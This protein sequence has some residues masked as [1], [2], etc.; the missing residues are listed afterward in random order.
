MTP[1]PITTAA[2]AAIIGGAVAA[3]GGAPP[4]P[5]IIASLL[6]ALCSAWGRPS[7]RPDWTLGYI[8]GTLVHTVLSCGAGMSGAVLLPAYMHELVSVPGWAVAGP[9]AFFSAR[10]IPSV[11]QVKDALIE[12]IRGRASTPSDSNSTGGQP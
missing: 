9:A 8:G 6:G 2:S 12:R 10:L 1:D 4:D 5:I 7:Q 11:D 3:A